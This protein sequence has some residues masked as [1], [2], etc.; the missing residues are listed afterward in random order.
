MVECYVRTLCAEI[1][2][3]QMKAEKAKGR[4]DRGRKK[5]LTSEFEIKPS[6]S[7]R[8]QGGRKK[9]RLSNTES[10]KTNYKKRNYVLKVYCRSCR[11]NNP[12]GC[13]KTRI[14]VS[15]VEKMGISLGTVPT[16]KLTKNERV[17]TRQEK[18]LGSANM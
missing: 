18:T 3:N 17:S 16:R 6:S 5:N 10:Y 1:R 8:N 2:F 11:H 12:G 15:T 7:V 9:M 4:K 13:R 14:V